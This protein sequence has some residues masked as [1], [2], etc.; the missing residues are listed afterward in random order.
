MACFF[1]DC[2]FKGIGK[3]PKVQ[4]V[5]Q[6]CQ[7]HLQCMH[8]WCHWHRRNWR[9]LLPSINDTGDAW[10]HWC[11]RHWWH[12][13]PLSLTPANTCFV[14]VVDTSEY[15]L[16]QCQWHRRVI[17]CQC[18]W[19]LW[20]SLKQQKC[21]WPMLLTPVRNYSPVSM[22]PAMHAL[23]VTLMP[24]KHQNNRISLRIIEKNRN[25]F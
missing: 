10:R 15:M 18:R 19:H 14:S 7:R 20:S 23:P 6:R 2:S 12:T 13:S 17:F 9:S 3:L 5:H 16:R 11:Q 25:C 21:H 4:L 1:T 24:A 22:T 8:R